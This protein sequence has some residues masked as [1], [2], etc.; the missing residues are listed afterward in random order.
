MRPT[1]TRR[2]IVAIRQQE[3]EAFHTRA[4]FAARLK[5]CPSWVDDTLERTP[6]VLDYLARRLDRAKREI[7]Q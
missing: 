7:C 1:F 5:V 2:M 4:H 6:P 3:K